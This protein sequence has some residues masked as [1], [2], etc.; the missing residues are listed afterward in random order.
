MI[1]II[2]LFI[3]L[4]CAIAYEFRHSVSHTGNVWWMILLVMWTVIMG[5]RYE[6][7]GDTY[8]YMMSY[9]LMDDLND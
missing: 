9:H 8:N 6:V 4:L 1:Y 7:G 3:T 5:I 2:P